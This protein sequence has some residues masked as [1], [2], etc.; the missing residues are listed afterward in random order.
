MSSRWK[1]FTKSRN[2]ILSI[3]R[4]NTG[5]SKTPS[6]WTPWLKKRATVFAVRNSAKYR[7]TFKVRHQTWQQIC[8][9]S[10]QKN[11]IKLK[12]V[13]IFLVKSLLHFGV[14]A[15]NSS[16]FSAPCCI[17]FKVVWKCRVSQHTITDVIL[18]HVTVITA[19]SKVRQCGI[20]CSLKIMSFTSAIKLLCLEA[21]QQQQWHHTRHLFPLPLKLRPYSGTKMHALLLLFRYEEA[22]SMKKKRT[23]SITT[24]EY[25]YQNS[26][27]WSK[28][29]PIDVFSLAGTE[30]HS[31]DL[32]KDNINQ[33][34]HRSTSMCSV[35]VWVLMS[36]I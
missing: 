15:A 20:C 1:L 13:A 26:P 2:E 29:R 33:N 35:C 10:S 23:K 30:V 22:S 3:Q 11:P 28:V 8:E 32:H 9:N 6:H 5:G 4:T 18:P 36:C 25:N 14:I 34:Q 7:P 12:C 19:T 17:H 24:A 21:L 16:A 31:I 27:S